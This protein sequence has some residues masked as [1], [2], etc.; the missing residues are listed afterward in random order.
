MEKELNTN[1]WYYP[2]CSK[3]STG[4]IGTDRCISYTELKWQMD[5]SGLYPAQQKPI[6][7]QITDAN[8]VDREAFERLSY[9]R[10]HITEYVQDH[11]NLYICSEQTGNGKTSWAI[12]MLHTYFAQNAK[13][14]YEYLLGMFI[15]T[16]DLLLKLKDF[17]NPLPKN[18]INK[19]ENVDLAIFDDVALAELSKYDYMQLFNIINKRVMAEKSNIFTSN[20]TT[21]EGLEQIFGP[22]LASR[23]YNN[24]EIIELEGVDIR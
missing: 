7:L 4:C 10:K 14:N 13:G 12:R 24:S 6:K 11:N 22:R 23:I 8:E 20:I 21:F 1:C 17:N 3:H 2:V 15:N 5:N 9:I 18:Y 16:A 19:L